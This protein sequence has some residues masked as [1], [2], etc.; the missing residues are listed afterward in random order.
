MFSLRRRS[1]C[2]R[3]V[4]RILTF[5]LFL[6]F[7]LA[8]PLVRQMP[9]HTPCVTGILQV[10]VL[11]SQWQAPTFDKNEVHK[12]FLEYEKLFQEKNHKNLIHSLEISQDT[13]EF[14][15]I[16]FSEKPPFTPKHKSL[17]AQNLSD[18]VWAK[19]KDKK[20]SKGPSNP[21]YFCFSRSRC[22]THSDR[23]DPFSL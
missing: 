7:V 8:R 14:R 15:Y 23:H 4:L 12:R 5:Q 17:M 1:S 19:Y 20:T 3:L 18:D 2:I 21:H 16:T 6:V 13:S 22:C 10:S 11:F 9:S